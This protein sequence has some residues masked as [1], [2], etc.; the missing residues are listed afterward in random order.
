[1]DPVRWSRVRSIVEEALEVATDQRAACIERACAGDGNLRAEVDSVLGAEARGPRFGEGASAAPAR[2][3]EIGERV[4][5]WQL[6]RIVGE[7]G[8]GVVFLAHRVDGAFAQTAAV[9]VARRGSAHVLR[10]FER[11]RALLAGL[12]HP[13]IARLY[14]GG[15]TADGCPWFAM[16]FVEGLRIDLWCEQRGLDLD[17]RIDLFLRVCEPVQYAHARLVLHRDIKPANVLVTPAGEPRLLDFGI[18]KVLDAGAESPDATLTRAEG[19]PL[20]PAYASPEQLRGEPTH[21][22]ADVYALGVLLHELLVGARPRDERDVLRLAVGVATRAIDLPSRR[23]LREGS[24]LPKVGLGANA[25]SRRL[26]GDLDVILCTAMH[27]DPAR[28]YASVAHLIEDLERYRTDRPVLA[29]ADSTWYRVRKFASRNKVAVSAAAVVAGALVLGAVS[30]W[31]GYREALVAR[32]FA[33]AETAKVLRLSARQDLERLLSQA[34]A[35]RPITPAVVSASRAWLARAHV[36]ADMLPALRS[37]L[38][39]IAARAGR[40]VAVLRPADLAG[41][42]DRWWF[43]ELRALVGDIER[44]RTSHF[45]VTAGSE[46]Q[47][48]IGIERRIALALAVQ[49]DSVESEDARRRWAAS[50]EY[51]AREPRYA[52]LELAPRYGLVPLG[53]DPCS[54]LLE[55]ASPLTGSVPRRDADGALDVREDAGVVLVLIPGG[56]HSLGAQRDDPSSSNFDPNFVQNADAML[57]R[58]RIDPFF[59]SKWE[60]TGA[61]WTWITGAPPARATNRTAEE[62]RR[63]SARNPMEKATWIELRAALELVGLEL[64]S[65]GQWEVGARA[66]T[67]TPWWSGPSSAALVYAEN[68]ADRH[69]LSSNPGGGGRTIDTS[70]DDGWALHAP[71]G[72]FVANPLGLHDMLGN[73]SE[74]IADR[75]PRVLELASGSG[76]PAAHGDGRRRMVRGGAYNRNAEF[77]RV[78]YLRNLDESEMTAPS[79]GARPSLSFVADGDPWQD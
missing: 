29:R 45:G 37:T 8:M 59:L 36:L 30:A 24:V 11:E 44:M 53:P 42:E 13:A 62:Q 35:L 6:E 76:R 18:A 46:E 58:V 77:C 20:T 32:D 25:L 79:W 49:R 19:A 5:P 51:A 14:D 21:I 73:V 55:F 3:F 50:R 72:S 47:G 17:E 31:L 67:G 27:D 12:V 2:R 39:E 70:L 61:Q 43:E 48:G 15:S 64:P 63:C 16:E 71:V 78:T 57:Q 66:G 33:R 41:D 26:S 10:R 54:G 9:K 65:G 40:D 22:A 23:V 28:R 68:L 7:G 34:E 75:S 52:G 74:M 4:G 56:T 38:A 1:M 69:Y 60:L